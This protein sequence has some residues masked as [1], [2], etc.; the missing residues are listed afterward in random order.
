MRNPSREVRGEARMFE[1][2]QQRDVGK[3]MVLGTKDLRITRFAED[4]QKTHS[5]GRLK[6]VVLLESLL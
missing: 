5:M 3:G 1:F 4:L 6:D 2:L